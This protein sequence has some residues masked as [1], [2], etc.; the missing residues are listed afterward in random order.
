MVDNIVT[1]PLGIVLIVTAHMVF[2]GHSKEVTGI[3]GN[4]ITLEFILNATITKN[5]HIAVYRSGPHKIAECRP[6]SYCS[7]SHEYDVYRGKVSVFCN[8]SNLKRNHSDIYW[9]SLFM[10]MNLPKESDKVKLSVREDNRSSTDSP[11]PTYSTIP[12]HRGTS[13]LFVFYIVTV[14]VVLCVVLLAAVLSWLI[15]CL[16]RT[17]D[18]QQTTATTT[19]L[20]SHSTGNSSGVQYCTCTLGGLQHPG[21]SQKTSSSFRDESK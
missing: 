13:N 3:L 14:L 10:D 18:K 8:I 20:L 15:W 9:A 7:E 21:L 4:N 16:V 12:E 2:N 5:S 19:E 1:K 11:M 17:K 6:D